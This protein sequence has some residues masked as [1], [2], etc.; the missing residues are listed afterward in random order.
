M[1]HLLK[2]LSSVC[3]KTKFPHYNRKFLQAHLW[4]EVYLGG[5]GGEVKEG[6]MGIVQTR[7][8][9]IFHGGYILTTE[10]QIITYSNFCRVRALGGGGRD[11]KKT[12]LTL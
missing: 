7:A 11:L 10:R 4:Y 8:R 12:E 5:G 6:I 2:H 1:P 3:Q 9:S